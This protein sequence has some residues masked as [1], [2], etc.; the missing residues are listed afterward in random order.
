MFLAD[1][2][3][4]RH[5]WRFVLCLRRERLIHGRGFDSQKT[6]IPTQLSILCTGGAAGDREEGEQ[7]GCRAEA[8]TVRAQRP[9]GLLGSEELPSFQVTPCLGA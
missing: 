6:A 9:A 4:G 3:S 7:P 2:V 5:L 1:P 8:P